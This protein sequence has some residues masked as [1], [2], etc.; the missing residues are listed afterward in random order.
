MP[1]KMCIN[2][3]F[4]LFDYKE[5]MATS[6]QK[7]KTQVQVPIDHSGSKVTI[8]G[9]GQVGMACAFSIITQVIIEVNIFNCLIQIN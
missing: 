8:V 4:V 9:V 7:L 5:K 1:E 3:C 6:E 2:F